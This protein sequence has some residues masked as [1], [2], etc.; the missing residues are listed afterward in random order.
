[1][2]IKHNKNQIKAKLTL[3]SGVINCYQCHDYDK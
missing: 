3:E 1:M 2:K